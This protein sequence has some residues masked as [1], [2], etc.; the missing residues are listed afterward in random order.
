MNRSFPRH[1]RLPGQTPKGRKE[2]AKGEIIMARITIDDL[3]AAENLTPEQEEL[4]L[5]A[6]LK[7]FRPSLEALE[8]REVPAALTPNIDLHGGTLTIMAQNR[9]NNLAEVKYEN[10][11]VVASYNLV[12]RT[13][14]IESRLV[15]RIVYIGNEAPD[16][17]TNNTLIPSQ[18]IN[19]E[20][21]DTHNTPYA[22]PFQMT[23]PYQLPDSAASGQTRVNGERVGSNTPP[24]ITWKDAPLGTSTFTLTMKDIDV[25][26]NPG[27][28]YTHMVLTDI[29]SWATSVQDA[30]T[31]GKPGFNGSGQTPRYYG[32]NPPEMAPGQVHRY[33]WTLTA[34][35][36]NGQVLGQTTYQT[37][38]AYAQGAQTDSGWTA[39]NR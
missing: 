20:T 9:Q 28:E 26:E 39:P 19:M 23:G 32:P 10:G 36:V 35:D 21:G 31:F 38:F 34:L 18:F 37:T 1:K 5:G 7:S 27:G 3:P 29:P 8:T 15:Q 24:P 6:G 33:V 11:G 16:K 13:A 17:F 22:R 25:P 4:I 14:P 12:Q 2:P 30:V